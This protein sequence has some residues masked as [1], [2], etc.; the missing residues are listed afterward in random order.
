MVVVLVDVVW[1]FNAN[2]IDLHIELKSRGAVRSADGEKQCMIT[3][4]R[5]NQQKE[6]EIQTTK[7]RNYFFWCLMLHRVD[8]INGTETLPI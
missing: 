1:I 6:T 8:T 4:A 7:Q 2:Q 5:A 3:V